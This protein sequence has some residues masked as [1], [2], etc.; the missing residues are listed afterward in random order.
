MVAARNSLLPLCLIIE[1]KSKCRVSNYC[2]I[3]THR[4]VFL[5]KAP[6]GPCSFF[7][8]SQATTEKKPKKFRIKEISDDFTYIF[9]PPLPSICPCHLFGQTK[10]AADVRGGFCGNHMK[11]LITGRDPLPSITTKWQEWAWTLVIL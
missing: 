11:N 4:K 7:P 8:I 9:L 6:E 3:N 10:Q 1:I 5:L 2:L